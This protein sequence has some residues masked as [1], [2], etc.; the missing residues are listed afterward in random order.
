MGKRTA[1]AIAYSPEDTGPRLIA[2]GRD[3]AA[4]RI[5]AIAEQAGVAV[6]E[7]PALAVLLDSGL[8]PG[9][10]IPVWCWEAAAKIL[11]F[12]LAKDKNE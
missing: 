10:I 4:E 5:I 2:S 12:V 11:A 7:D 6:I 8:R 3:R 1:S 9:E